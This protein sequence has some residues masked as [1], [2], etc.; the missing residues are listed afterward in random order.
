VATIV[1][2]GDAYVYADID[3]GTFLKFNRLR[4]RTQARRGGWPR[5]R[6]PRD[7]RRVGYPRHGY[8]ESSDNRLNPATGSLMLRMV[9]MKHR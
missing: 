3:E 2:V 6:R 8:I 7:R 9:F 5:R 1:S 4:A